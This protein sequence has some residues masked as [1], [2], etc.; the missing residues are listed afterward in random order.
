MRVHVCWVANTG[1]FK[2]EEPGS[3]QI[4]TSY[5][6][7][8]LL[9]F[10]VIWTTFIIWFLC[11]IKRE[12]FFESKHLYLDRLV[13][14][15][16][17]GHFYFLNWEQNWLPWFSADILTDI[18]RVSCRACASVSCDILGTWFEPISFPE[19]A[20]LL[21][22]TKDARHF[23]PADRKCARALGTR[24]GLS[25]RERAAAAAVRC[26]KFLTAVSGNA[27]NSS[28]YFLRGHQ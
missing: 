5:V 18:R 27:T 25:E 21:V 6:S 2:P 8:L 11:V 26:V 28:T 24:L 15:D 7:C 13:A 22:S 9:L 12:I 4:G 3:V 17:S 1:N 23:D 14:H 20:F 16:R 10:I 19:A